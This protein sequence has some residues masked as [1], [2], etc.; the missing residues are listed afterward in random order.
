MASP[1]PAPDLVTVALVTRVLLLGATGLVGRSTLPLLLDDDRCE[2]VVTL[3]RRPP[4]AEHP[5]LCARVV[6]FED[7]PT[8]SEVWTV[9]AVISVLGTTRKQAGSAGAFRRVD[10]GYPMAVAE[11]ARTHGASTMVVTSAKGADPSSRLLYP[12]VKGEIER[13]LGRLSWESLTIVRPN[14]IGGERDESRPAEA[15][16]LKVAGLLGPV[17][18]RALRISPAEAITDALV[19]AALAPRPGTHLVDSAALLA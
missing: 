5:K 8:A 11:R 1:Y 9:D 6:D 2:E 14:I 16:G 17:L 3:T 15:L 12:Q 4:G 19:E 18:P 7:L 13:D 10:Y